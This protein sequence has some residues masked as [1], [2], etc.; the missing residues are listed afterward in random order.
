[1]KRYPLSLIVALCLV[2]I[3]LI[4]IPE[5]PLEQVPLYDKWVHFLMYGT[6][7]L[8][9]WWDYLHSHPQAVWRR[10]LPLTVVFPVALSGAMELAQAYL[11]TYRSGDWLDFAANCIGVALATLFMAVFLC[12]RRKRRKH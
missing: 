12:V 6:L 1:M 8:A 4:P 7:C 2:V 5:S 9:T 11:T 10:A 3:S